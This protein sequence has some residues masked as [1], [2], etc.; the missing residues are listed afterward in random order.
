[1][2]EQNEINDKIYKM[3]GKDAAELNEA[4]SAVAQLLINYA[5]RINNVTAVNDIGLFIEFMEQFVSLIDT[6]QSS[7]NNLEFGTLLNN[8]KL[9]IKKDMISEIEAQFYSILDAIDEQI[10]SGELIFPQEGS[11]ED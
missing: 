11:I 5:E 3:L 6:E 4:D 7:V 8:V 10:E 2:P 1:M 9:L